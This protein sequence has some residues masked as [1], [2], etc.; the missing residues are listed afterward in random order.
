MN[1]TKQFKKSSISIKSSLTFPSSHNDL[2]NSSG[3]ED[4]DKQDSFSDYDIRL[5]NLDNYQITIEEFQAKVESEV[6]KI[7]IEI[8]NSKIGNDQ[9]SQ[10]PT[11]EKFQSDVIKSI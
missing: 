3:S 10:S 2:L 9:V 4:Q 7:L 8:Y 6:I 5:D 11:I 1:K